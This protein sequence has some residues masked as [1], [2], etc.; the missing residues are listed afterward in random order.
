[1]ALA[2]ELTEDSL[3]AGK[4]RCLQPRQGYRFSVDAVLLAHFISPEHDARILDLGAGCG[5]VSLIL[6]HRWPGVSLVALEVQ[7]RL[8][9]IIRRNVAINGLENRVTVIE[10]D[11]RR[12]ETLLPLGSCDL[13]VANP[14]YYQTG[15]G[16]HHPETERTKARHEILGGISEM[17]PAAAC[18]LKSGGRAAFVYPALRAVTLLG[19]LR[20]NGLEPKR[21][22]MVYPWPGALAGLVLVE[23]VKDGGEELAILPPFYIC[24]EKDGAYTPEMAGMYA[25]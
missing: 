22:R 11:C 8:A 1:M 13:V 15:S 9:G 6:S 16:R 4:L 14:P 2:T 12:I 7:S 18:V 21:L 23:A 17:A 5:V 24:Q 25:G 19:V 10:G 20:E 3:F